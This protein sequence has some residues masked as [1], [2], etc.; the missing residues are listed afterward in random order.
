[1]DQSEVRDAFEEEECLFCIPAPHEPCEMYSTIAVGDR[2]G[3]PL[4]ED[5]SDHLVEV[6]VCH[7]H[8][9][10]FKVYQGVSNLDE[11]RDRAPL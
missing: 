3:V 6:P 5:I 2:S 10:A 11:V 1:M 8:L 9:K 4:G 7:R